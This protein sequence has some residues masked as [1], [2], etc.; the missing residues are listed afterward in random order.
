MAK[1]NIRK[2]KGDMMTFFILTLISSALIFISASF[3]VGTGRVVDTNMKKINAA[4][5]LCLISDD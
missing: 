5:V 3:L 4:D 1:N 2:Q